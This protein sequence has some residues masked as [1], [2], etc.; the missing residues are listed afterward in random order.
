[1]NQ[2]IRLDIKKIEQMQELEL[3]HLLQ[4]N[5][6][7]SNEFIKIS[8]SKNKLDYLLFNIPIGKNIVFDWCESEKFK[9]ADSN[10]QK[11]FYFV[12]LKVITDNLS[13]LHQHLLK[14]NL[15]LIRPE[16]ITFCQN[17][18][19][20]TRIQWLVLPS[21]LQ[22]G[23]PV[24]LIK[25]KSGNLWNYISDSKTELKNIVM[26]HYQLV[27][28]DRYKEARDLLN[29]NVK[30]ELLVNHS[31]DFEPK[32][33][34]INRKP[35]AIN[36]VKT[37]RKSETRNISKSIGEVKPHKNSFIK[38]FMNRLKNANRYKKT[39]PS[40][41]TVPLNP[42]DDLF[43]LAM[44]SE[45]PP[46]TL[47]E[48]EGIR[49]FVLVDEFLIGRD[50]MICDLVL[51]QSTIGRVHARISRHGSHYFLEDLGSANGTTLDEKNSTNIKPIC[52]RINVV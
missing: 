14:P 52:Y 41:T 34:K 8:D 31:V 9:T 25:Q 5:F 13:E 26:S 27:A 49:A 11:A 32:A 24:S 17:Y 23:I 35:K 28:E 22:I 44:L 51:T 12:L 47:A 15:N 1:M 29:N 30:H 6:D 48:S 33:E 21:D 3:L 46:G 38:K 45:G 19:T 42:Q 10:L 20:I 18:A 7:F 39:V 36:R 43:R 40:E 50:R 2:Y 4:L 16:L 37:K